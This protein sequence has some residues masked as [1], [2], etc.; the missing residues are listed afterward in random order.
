MEAAFST[1]VQS[2]PCTLLYK[3]KILIA[4]VCD[5]CFIELMRFIPYREAAGLLDGSYRSG[6]LDHSTSFNLSSAKKGLVQC[7]C[8]A[9]LPIL[10]VASW[11]CPNRG[12]DLRQCLPQAAVSFNRNSWFCPR[13]H[14][15]LGKG[16]ASCGKV[17]LDAGSGGGWLP[18]C[19]SQKPHTLYPGM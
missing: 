5:D 15:D 10:T 12:I 4:S 18:G 6:F 16:A 14:G 9:R 2:F 1:H 13:L 19:P 11:L 3:P 8:A 17:Y 7:V